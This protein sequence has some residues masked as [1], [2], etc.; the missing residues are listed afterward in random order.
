MTLRIAVIGAGYWGPN[1]VRNFRGNP[2]WDLVAVCD[3]DEA[4]ARKVIGARST[5]EVETSLQRLLARDDI[6]A[7]AIATPA[8]TH[9][10]IAHAALE[11]GKHVLVEKPL[12]DSKAEA[13]RMVAAAS[14]RDL[15]LMIDHT[16]C[17]TPVVERIREFITEGV[18]GDILFIDSSHVAKIGSDVVYLMTEVLPQLRPGV[19]VHFHDVF[20]P[21]EY[22]EEW[23]QEGRAWNETYMLKAFLQFNERFRILLFCSYLALHHRAVLEQHLPLAL[24]NSGGS[25]WLRTS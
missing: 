17:Y 7:V 18:L 8:A 14:E 20:W 15:V 11:A 22:P 1:L 13:S 23:V 16:Y 24:K 9:S 2:N 3:L 25:L 21:F 10:P 19:L 5:V 4:R 6:D 12:A